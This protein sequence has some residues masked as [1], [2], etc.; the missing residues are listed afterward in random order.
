MLNKER[1]KVVPVVA[2]YGQ[3]SIPTIEKVSKK[4]MNLWENKIVL[5]KS[6][7]Q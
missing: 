7:S 3:P 6:K 2:N 5:L 1:I 4:A